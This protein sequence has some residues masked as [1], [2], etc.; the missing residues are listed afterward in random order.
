MT[1]ERLRRSL[2]NREIDTRTR[3]HTHRH[4]QAEE[5]EMRITEVPFDVVSGLSSVNGES[6]VVPHCMQT[7]GDWIRV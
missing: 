2:I 3:G 1:V 4:R 6:L 7:A 5:R